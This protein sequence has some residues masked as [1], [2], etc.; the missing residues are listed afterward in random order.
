MFALAFL[1]RIAPLAFPLCVSQR[2]SSFF[3]GL[4]KGLVK[5]DLFPL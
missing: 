2:A 3:T 1:K 4:F 5:N